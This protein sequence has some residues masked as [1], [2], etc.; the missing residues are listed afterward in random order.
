MTTS[1]SHAAGRPVGDVVVVG[2]GIIGWSIAWRAATAGLQVTVIDPAPSS[3]ASQVAA[4]MLA[5]VSEVV[6]GEEDLLSLTIAGA[7]HWPAFV[8][9]LE[10]A[11]GTDV[12]YRPAATLLVGADA[13]D[14]AALRDLMTFQQSLGLDVEPLSS[15]ASRQREP[16]LSPR[17]AGGVLAA[18]DHH[19][20]PRRVMDALQ[21]AAERAGVVLRRVR[22]E[23]I[24]YQQGTVTGVGLE[25]GR[26]LAA[27]QVVLAAGTRSPALAAGLEDVAVPVRPVKGELLVLGPRPDS[28]IPRGTVRGLVHGRSVYLVPRSDGRLVVGATQQERPGDTTVTAGGVRRLL[29]DAA[30]LVP[31]IDELEVLETLAGA[32]PGTPDNRP[33]V[34]PS[35]LD[36]LLLATGHHRHG[37]LLAPVTATS[38]V[39]LL[40]GRTPPP[41][42]LVAD[43][44]R[45]TVRVGAGS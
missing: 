40:T 4:G 21:T 39:A 5:P 33:L 1:T 37:V 6:Y 34:G 27:G 2:A 32:R 30:A 42:I 38:I 15:R 17:I 20:D 7:R 10:A 9:E 29:D 13:S 18:S 22:A 26:H 45:E 19:V 8:H 3:G 28:E 16:L 14:V 23:T 43:P 31:A 12:G 35:G 44:R 24:T 25:D 11:S 36:G 41:P